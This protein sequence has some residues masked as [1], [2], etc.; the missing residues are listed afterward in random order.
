MPPTLRDAKARLDEIIKKGRVDLYKPIQIAE[1]LNRSRL[2]PGLDVTNL[3]S[4]Q[5]LSTHWRDNITTRFTGKKSTSSA[6]YQHDVWSATAM[7]PDYLS[8]LDRE[9]KLTGGQLSDIFM[10]FISLGNKRLVKLLITSKIPRH[11]N[12]N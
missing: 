11:A 5:N 1:V 8:V 2:T 3:Q 6:R 4:Y 12:F 7:P 10:G 9:N